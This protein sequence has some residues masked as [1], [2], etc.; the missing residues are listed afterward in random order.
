MMFKSALVAA[1]V[2]ATVPAAMAKTSTFGILPNTLPSEIAANTDFDLGWTINYSAD[3]IT[4]DDNSTIITFKL[5]KYQSSTDSNTGIVV[6]DTLGTSYVGAKSVTTEISTSDAA[7]CGEYCGIS[8]VVDSQVFYPSP[9]KTFTVGSSSSGSNSGSGNST[10]D[11]KK[12]GG[13]AN[14]P[15]L[16]AGLIAAV[17][18]AFF[19]L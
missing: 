2:A 8:F 19:A 14:V 13:N 16:A 4:G 15:G 12:N 3:T 7:S 18:A 11:T 6:N 5:M 10:D 9:F 17:G 1:A